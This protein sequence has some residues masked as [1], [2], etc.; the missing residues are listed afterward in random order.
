M[1]KIAAY[2][3]QDILSVGERL[4]HLTGAESLVKC[5]MAAGCSHI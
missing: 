3:N 5:L 1:Q 4:M 2:E